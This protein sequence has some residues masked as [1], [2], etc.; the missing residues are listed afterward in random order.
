MMLASELKAVNLNVVSP[1]D[2]HRQEAI[3]QIQ[4]HLNEAI[5]ELTEADA[6][7]KTSTSVPI[8]AGRELA[9]LVEKARLL[10]IGLQEMK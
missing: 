4:S 8:D 10:G 2:K 3:R 9:H 7:A 1:A 5:S 6:W